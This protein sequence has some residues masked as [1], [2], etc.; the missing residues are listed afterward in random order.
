MDQG[1]RAFPKSPLNTLLPN[2][3]R[4][5]QYIKYHYTHVSG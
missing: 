3:N 2:G 1:R 4:K 5:R